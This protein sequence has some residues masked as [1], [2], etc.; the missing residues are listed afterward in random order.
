[1]NSSPRYLKHAGKTLYLGAS[2]FSM[3]KRIDLMS[4]FYSLKWS[5]KRIWALFRNEIETLIKDKQSL[6]IVFLVPV[7]IL[8][9]FYRPPGQESSLDD[10]FSFDAGERLG[11]LDLDTTTDWEGEDLSENFTATFEQNS[12]YT[13]EP[14][15][16]RNDGLTKLKAGYIIGFIIIPDKFEEN[17]TNHLETTIQLVVDATDVEVAASLTATIEIVIVMFKLTHNLIKDEIYPISFQQFKASS[18]LFESG[19]IIFSIMIFGAA[20]LLTSQSIVGD[21]P[22]KRTLLTPAGKMEVIVAKTMA[23]SAIHAIQVQS[24]LFLSM[25]VFRLPVYCP[26]YVAFLQ[27]FLL[28]F[29]GIMIGMFISMISK[30]RLQANQLF[31]LVFIVMLLSL[32]FISDPAVTDWLPMYQGVDGFTT[33]AFKGFTLREAP[34]PAFSMVVISIIFLILT[35]IAFYFKKTIE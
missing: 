22:L 12:S 33:V 35:I 13:M 29:A 27:L 19:P 18:P 30:T 17:I 23:Y 28:A 16:D 2:S 15:S 25:T 7:A 32:I 21:E 24:M 8:I 26:F 1:M 3:M 5:F 14:L 6:L 20:L 34:W 31:L 11:Y 4:F 9:P 10:M